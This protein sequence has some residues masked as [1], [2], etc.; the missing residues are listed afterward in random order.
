MAKTK[1]EGGAHS[2]VGGSQFARL[3]LCPG[4]RRKAAEAPP[5]PTS[6]WAAEGTAVHQVIEDCLARGK[7]GKWKVEPDA[8]LGHHFEIDGHDIEIEPKHVEAARVMVDLVRRL[9]RPKKA[10]LFV[11]Q[12]FA[13]KSVDDEAYGTADAA[14]WNEDTG[15][16]YVVDYKNGAGKFVAADHNLQL[17]FYAA[18]VIEKLKINPSDV[19][20]AIVQPNHVGGEPVRWWTVDIFEFDEWHQRLKDIAAA[21]RDPEA[22]LVPGDE[23]CHWCAA[24]SICEA[25]ATLAGVPSAAAAFGQA[26]DDDLDAL[27]GDGSAGAVEVAPPASRELQLLTTPVAL[28]A[29]AELSTAL[30]LCDALE[31]RVKEI[32]QHAHER[33]EGGVEIPDRVLEPTK[34][35]RKWADEERAH[36]TLTDCGLTDDQIFERKM[37]TPAAAEKLLPAQYKTAIQNVVHRVS[38]GTKLVRAE[39]AKNPL[40]PLAQQVFATEDS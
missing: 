28:L 12:K 33:A 18:G 24:K 40:P 27:L 8:Y 9:A 34:P 10:R 2:P 13:L 32:R 38:S 35:V 5:Q 15:V 19:H 16:L 20:M 39:N 11:E 31:K 7:G 17:V 6:P 1:L 25:R 37:V 26:G 14:V 21:T 29:P 36:T 22:P 4:S 23:Q 30:D 3:A